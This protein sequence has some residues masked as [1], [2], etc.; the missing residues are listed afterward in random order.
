M[1]QLPR[2]VPGQHGRGA[3]GPLQRGW[4]AHRLQ[5]GRVLYAQGSAGCPGPCRDAPT[6][7]LVHWGGAGCPG[8]C[9]CPGRECGGDPLRPGPMAGRYRCRE[10]GRSGGPGGA[11]GCRCGCCRYPEGAVPDCAALGGRGIPSA[12]G[13]GRCGCRAVRSRARPAGPWDVRS[14]RSRC[15]CRWRAAVA[16]SAAAMKGCSGAAPPQPASAV[17]APRAPGAGSGRTERSAGQ[18]PPP[19]AWPSRAAAP[20][21]ECARPAPPRTDRLGTVRGRSRWGGRPD[22]TGPAPR[23]GVWG[24]RRSGRGALGARGGP[25]SG[26]GA[27]AGRRSGAR[28]GRG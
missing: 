18:P 11:P 13:P 19:P 9:R 20:D 5:W 3:K 6:D 15:R 26:R 17:H 1:L 24:G 22:G 4:G 21:G 2:G 27:G 10:Q 23:R 8:L 25:G 7:G 16:G 28:R 14:G 12:R